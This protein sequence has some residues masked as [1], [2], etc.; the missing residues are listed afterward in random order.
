MGGGGGVKIP[1]IF[2]PFFTKKSP[3]FLIKERPKK[4]KKKSIL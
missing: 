1:L 2:L 3:E 4:K